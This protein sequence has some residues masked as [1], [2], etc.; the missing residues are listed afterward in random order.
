M[1]QA[2]PCPFC[3]GIELAPYDADSQD[4]DFESIWMA[5]GCETCGARGPAAC[6]PYEDEEPAVIKWNRRI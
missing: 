5:I 3:G 6:C 1:I 2:L 4:D